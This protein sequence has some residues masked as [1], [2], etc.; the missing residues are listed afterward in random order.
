MRKMMTTGFAKGKRLQRK[1][2]AW[3]KSGFN[4]CLDLMETNGHISPELHEKYRC[5]S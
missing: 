3:Y 1:L 2:N 4:K 5:K